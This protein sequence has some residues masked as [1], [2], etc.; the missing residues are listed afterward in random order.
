MKGDGWAVKRY[1]CPCCKR[2]GLYWKYGF[3]WMCMY[4]KCGYRTSDTNKVIEDNQEILK[5]GIQS[6][7]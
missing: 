7:P 4:A 2:K 6:K 3:D 1:V 5:E